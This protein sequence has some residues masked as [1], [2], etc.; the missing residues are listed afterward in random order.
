MHRCRPNRD[1][2]PSRDQGASCAAVELRLADVDDIPR[3]N[4]VVEASLATWDVAERV[5]RLALPSLSY[6]AF[7]ARHMT[8]VLAEARGAVVGVAAWEPAGPGDAPPGRRALLLHGLFVVPQWQRQGVGAALLAAARRAATDARA[9]GVVVR[10]WREAEG[11]FLA[12][13]MLGFPGDAPDRSP[14]RL[15]RGCE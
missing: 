3:I 5:R 2:V 13:G 7:D 10:A 12:Q 8:F 11:F 1:P 6:D 14:R 9:D 15:W 4:R